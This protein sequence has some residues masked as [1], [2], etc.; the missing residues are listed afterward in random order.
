MSAT[1]QPLQQ[2]LL[3]DLIREGLDVVHSDITD[4]IANGYILTH[5]ESHP[6]QLRNN[7]KSTLFVCYF[8]LLEHPHS[9]KLQEMKFPGMPEGE[10]K[11]A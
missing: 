10:I 4:T 11:D 8:V 7:E 3:F 1:K 9:D 2:I 6:R 5:T